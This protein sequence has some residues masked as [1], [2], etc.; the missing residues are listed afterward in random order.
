MLRKACDL[1]SLSPARRL[2]PL[3]LFF[4]GSQGRQKKRL[5][6]PSDSDLFCFAW[7][8]H[9]GPAAR[10]VL[11]AFWA[12]VL[13]H[14]VVMYV[15]PWFRPYSSLRFHPTRSSSLRFGSRTSIRPCFRSK[16][17]LHAGT[18]RAFSDLSALDLGSSQTRSEDNTIIMV[19]VKIETMKPDSTKTKYRRTTNSN[20]SVKRKEPSLDDLQWLG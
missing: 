6:K 4:R 19:K 12:S 20:R 18:A 17:F 8:H 15:G 13:L 1:S 2:K 5:D 3:S 10:P 16:P 9:W 11:C 14:I 7:G